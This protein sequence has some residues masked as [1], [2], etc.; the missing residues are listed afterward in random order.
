MKFSEK[1]CRTEFKVT[2]KADG[3]EA[4][5]VKKKPCALL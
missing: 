5:V 3:N 1:K 4:V 2:G